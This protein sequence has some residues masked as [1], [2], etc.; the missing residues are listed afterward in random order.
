MVMDLNAVK[1]FV[2]TAEL[3]SFTKAA[4]TL[5]MTQSGVSRAVDRLESDL[6][7]KLLYRTTRSLSLTPD[8]QA[9][10]ER[11]SLLLQEFEDAEHK[12]IG[13]QD[14]PSGILKI[15]SPLGFGR[16]VLLP[17]LAQ[18]SK[19][20][21]DLTIDVT[22][23]DR[24]VDLTS[25]G[26]DASIRIGDIPDSNVIVKHLG[27]I[28]LVTIASPDYLKRCGIPKSPEKLSQHNCLNLRYPRTGRLFQW[29]FIEEGKER[30]L[31]VKGNMVLDLGDG[32][33]DLAIQGHGIVQTQGF[34]AVQALRNKQVMAIL[35]EYAADRGPVSL[36]YP[37]SRQLSSKMR[38][39]NK[40][41]S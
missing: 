40:M 6:R 17:L 8:G 28:R 16:A 12:L 20:H 29:R 18:L 3:G 41:L 5:K 33:V 30:R 10:F 2:R 19:T 14:L 39:L 15:S 1:I 13:Q 35:E 34:M 26:F 9:F 24:M 37:E 22:M 4:A 7:S 27:I 11:C 21:P 23:T 31:S 38:V 25:E 32:L 36:I